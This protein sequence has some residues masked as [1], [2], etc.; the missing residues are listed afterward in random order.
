MHTTDWR[1][2]EINPTSKTF[3]C[4]WGFGFVAVIQRAKEFNIFYHNNGDGTFT[5]VT[6]TVGLEG[7]GWSSDAAIFDFDDDGDQDVL[8][9]CM[10]GRAQ[11]L[12]ND[13]GKFT[14]VTLETL[15]RTPRGGRGVKVVAAHDGSDR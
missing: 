12:R 10:F 9:T 7:R 6:R 1:L 3:K 15:G 4:E 14:D 8:I 2:V 11:L 13:D 5:D